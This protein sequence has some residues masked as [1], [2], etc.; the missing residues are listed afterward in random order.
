MARVGERVRQ[1]HDR[2]AWL[3]GATWSEID[4]DLLA[5][6]GL[7]V[8]LTGSRPA[9]TDHDALD[10]LDLIT[11]LKRLRPATHCVLM[12]AVCSPELLLQA[13][14][15]GTDAIL[16]H[17]FSADEFWHAL[18]TSLTGQRVLPAAARQ[19]LADHLRATLPPARDPA[20]ETLAPREI[21]L[22]TLL[23]QNLLLKEADGY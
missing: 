11:R 14:L 6:E 21:E 7:G 10:G 4:A 16:L 2:F 9:T 1:C 18:Q 13:I 19:Q 5:D 12:T 3:G 22:L 8:L 17:P 15:A 23:E 20:D